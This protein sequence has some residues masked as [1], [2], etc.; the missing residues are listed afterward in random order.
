MKLFEV[1][2]EAVAYVWAKDYREAERTAEREINEVMEGADY[3]A[4][5]MKV[6]SPVYADWTGSCPFGDAPEEFDGMTMDQISDRW[7]EEDAK[8][9]RE[10]LPLFTEG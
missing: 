4:N 2:V 6:G 5:E 7:R 1:H 8:V 3:T 9:D 10:T